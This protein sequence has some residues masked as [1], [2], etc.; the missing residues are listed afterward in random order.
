MC[1]AHRSDCGRRASDNRRIGR[2]GRL[3]L[4]ALRKIWGGEADVAERFWQ[5]LPGNVP[6]AAELLPHAKD[7]L[8]DADAAVGARPVLISKAV[9][10]GFGRP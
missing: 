5:T 10:A 6:Y 1:E 9:R 8:A 3:V 2:R 7:L 4:R